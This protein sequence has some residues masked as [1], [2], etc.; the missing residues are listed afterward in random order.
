M[1]IFLLEALAT[2]K[3]YL[4]GNM[5]GASG[6]ARLAA[7]VLFFGLFVAFWILSHRVVI[8]DGV[9]T[10]TVLLARRKSIR[11]EDIA[12]A[13]FE[14]GGSREANRYKPFIRITI[15]PKRGSGAAPIDINAK[16]LEFAD[17]NLLLTTING[18]EPP[19]KAHQPRVKSTTT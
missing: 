16:V 13:K 3:L 1:G 15:K 11:L 17:I 5:Y 2:T 19:A 14:V 7:C 8:K 18:P 6:F 9:L 4:A 12:S 10:Y